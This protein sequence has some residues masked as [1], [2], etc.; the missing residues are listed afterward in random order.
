[1]LNGYFRSGVDFDF[2]HLGGKARLIPFLGLCLIT[3]L[4]LCA[5]EVV[6]AQSPAATQAMAAQQRGDFAE[7]EKDWRAAVAGNPEDAVVHTNLV[8]V[9]PAQ[10]TH[11]E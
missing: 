9:L 8:C 2:V 4:C 3:A 5:A 11:K 6:V 10:N 7:A 1:M